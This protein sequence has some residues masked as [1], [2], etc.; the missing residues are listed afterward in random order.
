[1]VACPKHGIELADRC[2]ACESPV[3]VHRRE[4]GRR[5]SYPDG[6]IDHCYSCQQDLTR[7]KSRDISREEIKFHRFLEEGIDNGWMLAPNGTPVYTHLYLDVLHQIMKLL[8]STRSRN[9]GAI[10]SKASGFETVNTPTPRSEIEHLTVAD[11]RQLLLQAQWLLSDWP[12]RFV[13]L[14]RDN[15]IWS[16]WLLRDLT[17]VPWWFAS[18]IQQELFVQYAPFDAEYNRKHIR[19]KGIKHQH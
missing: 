18:V 6:A 1:M 15:Q 14:C 2:P 12:E 3:C 13:K 19:Y 9:L 17:E 16:S 10:V 11:R 5:T 7:T 4:M 8:I